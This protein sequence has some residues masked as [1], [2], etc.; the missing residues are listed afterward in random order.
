MQLSL[1]HTMAH[2]LQFQFNYVLAKSIDL[3]SDSERTDYN[4]GQN[5]S[6]IVNAWN[7]KGNRGV[8]DFDTRHA[9]SGNFNYLLP[10]GKGATFVSVFQSTRGCSG[11][12]MGH[13]RPGA[14]DERASILRH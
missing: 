11:R 8:S 6:S 12:R 9:I 7:I 4:K 1:H 2:G 10:F 3:G 14:L 5:F 13:R